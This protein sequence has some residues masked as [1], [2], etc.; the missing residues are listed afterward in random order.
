[1]NKAMISLASGLEDP[2]RVT[3]A[4]LVA[5]GAAEQCREKLMFLTK[6]AVRIALTGFANVAACDGCPP[7][8]G[9]LDRYEAA[10]DS[11]CAPSA[12]TPAR[13]IGQALPPTPTPT[14]RLSAPCS[15]GRGSVRTPLSR[16]AIS[17][18]VAA[19]RTCRERRTDLEL[20]GG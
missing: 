7:L 3:V 11:S 14:P 6:E 8:T 20:T 4:F 17:A 10:G 5:V 18:S 15:C 13:W 12:L 9:L 2:E 19:T 16:L 1:M